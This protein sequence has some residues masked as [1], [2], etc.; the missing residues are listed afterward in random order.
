MFCVIFK[1]QKIFMITCLLLHRRSDFVVIALHCHE[2]M[3]L[4]SEHNILYQL[5][6]IFLLD[7]R[8][9]QIILGYCYLSDLLTFTTNQY[10]DYY[11]IVFGIIYLCLVYFNYALFIMVHNFLILLLCWHYLYKH[12]HAAA[13]ATDV[14][15]LKSTYDHYNQINCLQH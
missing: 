4:Q 14:V 9:H 3:K 5:L 6:Y 15:S 1:L 13:F 8:Q 12:L 10:W 11:I 7:L 2:L